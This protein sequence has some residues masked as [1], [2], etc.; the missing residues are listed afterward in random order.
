MLNTQETQLCPPTEHDEYPKDKV[1]FHA[2]F[3]SLVLLPPSQLTA[4]L[5][6]CQHSTNSFTLH[7]ER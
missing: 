1:L 2:S 4:V 5:R 7:L 6:G 3:R